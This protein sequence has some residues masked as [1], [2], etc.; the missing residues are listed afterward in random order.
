MAEQCLALA[1]GA[2]DASLILEANHALSW[3]S[4]ALGRLGC[5][6]EHVEATLRLYRPEPHGALAFVYG[7]DPGPHS[8]ALLSWQLWLL[9]WPDQALA[10]KEHALAEAR[11]HDHKVTLGVCQFYA[12][13]LYELRRE[14][15]RLGEVAAE[16]MATCREQGVGFYLAL[17]TVMHGSALVQ[18]GGADAIPSL[19]V[20]LASYLRTGALVL[21]PYL[22]AK[23]ADAYRVA[24]RPDEALRTIDKALAAAERSQERWFEADLHRC[25]GELL[26]AGD[27]ADRSGAE[28]C[29]RR[30]LDVARHTGARSLELRAT[31]SLVRRW[32]DRGKRA[33]AHDL[34]API[35]GWFTEGFDTPDLI[36][37]K[38]LLEALV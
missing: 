35:Y 9:G 15:A 2:G 21:T 10:A 24:G 32:G 29:F 31:M 18:R 19:R 5:A 28:A 36:E 37:A 38:Q 4:M 6:R 20:G 17:L 25:R 23:L 14:P 7:T 26:L 11:A 13:V 8:R 22:R 34:L 3:T 33:E 12:A 16:G 1:E 27:E 30:A